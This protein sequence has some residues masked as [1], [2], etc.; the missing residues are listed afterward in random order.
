[1]TPQ[2]IG[3]AWIPPADELPA[4]PHYRLKRSGLL[5]AGGFGA[6]Y[7]AE[8][9]RFDP[10]NCPPDF[11][12]TVAVKFL[13]GSALKN[14]PH[15]AGR[16]R[17]VRHQ[18]L[19]PMLDFLDLRGQAGW[20][21]FAIVM[22]L[23]DCSLA[24]LFDLVREEATPLPQ[25]TAVRYAGHL[26]LALN[27]LHRSHG[28]VHRD[29]KPANLFLRL[30]PGTR[31]P[32]SA[33]SY[34]RA[35]LL[36]ADLGVADRAGHKATFKLDRD[37]WKP[38]ELP[39]STDDQ[40]P[41]PAEDIYAFGKVLLALAGAV[42]GSNEFPNRLG[43]VARTCLVRDP[44]SRPTAGELL[45]LLRAVDVSPARLIELAKGLSEYDVERGSAAGHAAAGERELVRAYAA[46]S[47]GRVELCGTIW[48]EANVVWRRADPE[49]TT[50]I[51]PGEVFARGTTDNMNWQSAFMT[52]GEHS[53]QFLAALL[54]V[55]DDSEFSPEARSARARV[56]ALLRPPE[57][58]TGPAD[59]FR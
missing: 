50:K 12:P 20:P 21:P 58:G 42:D 31:N 2:P 18:H 6:V 55:Q 34:H 19:V 32:E 25:S 1:M 59:G 36:L 24:G 7:A 8:D 30:P 22:E 48:T 28:L 38:P 17:Q 57:P 9:C 45:D 44:A 23:C 51:P 5:G 40:Y 33:L 43:A 53:G 35:D 41:D 54:L 26:A 13:F 39:P 4:H 11:H 49:R 47:K 3:P 56:L 16:N 46:V 37:D 10:K 14:A 15:E 27:A 52:A 29:I